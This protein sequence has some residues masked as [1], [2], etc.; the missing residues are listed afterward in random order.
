MLDEADRMLDLG[1]EPH[2]RAIAGATRADRQ[3]LMFSATWPT[4]VRCAAAGGGRGCQ[5]ALLPCVLVLVTGASAV[6]GT[7]CALA[8]PLLAC[9][10]PSPSSNCPASCPPS[11]PPTPSPSALP[12]RLPQQAGRR[13]FVPPRKG[14][15]RVAGSGSLALGH[16]GAPPLFVFAHRPASARPAQVACVSSCSA[17]WG[18]MHARAR[19]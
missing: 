6:A 15:D 14:D 8:R 16:S 2:I 17:V 11:F 1:F 10:Q 4:I 13:L 9:R 7:R 18:Y 3:T 12:A 19:G 5:G